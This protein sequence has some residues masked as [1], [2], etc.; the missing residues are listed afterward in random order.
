[1][2]DVAGVNANAAMAAEAP[3]SAGAMLRAAREAQG[4]HIAALAVALKVPVKKIEALEADRFQELLDTV[5]VRS[6][7]MSVCR[8]LKIDP[9]PVL[10]LLP[11][12]SEKRLKPMDGGL[13]THFRDNSLATQRT[14]R[15]QLLSPIG[16]SAI[17]LLVATLVVL[18]WQSP[19]LESAGA[20]TPVAG[21][22]SAAPVAAPAVDVPAPQVN[23]AVAV[24]SENPVGAAQVSV[25]DGNVPQVNA[26]PSA[27]VVLEL[28]ARGVSWVEVNDAD[29]VARLRKLTA[30][31]EVLQ[32]SG[33]LPL[34][35][36]LGRADQLDVLVRGQP[37]DVTSALRDNV[38]RFEV[39]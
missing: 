14:W 38:A 19:T 17:A 10:A 8:T 29:G 26:L 27:P 1:M 28:R 37:F 7:A 5:F 21:V 3:A 24:G 16:L 23:A 22:P 20:P 11:D 34:A 18:V 31:G 15:S 25:A 4:L 39:K 30:A 2:S 12:A 32:I 33:K 9:E 6:L 13:N 35:V 36:V